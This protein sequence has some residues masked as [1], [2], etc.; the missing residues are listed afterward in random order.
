[1]SQRTP[2]G[3]PDRL[4]SDSRPT[5][6]LPPLGDDHARPAPSR[7]VFLQ[8]G[9]LALLSG[10]AR[11]AALAVS[12]PFAGQPSALK[13]QAQYLSEAGEFDSAMRDLSAAAGMAATSDADTLR[14]TSLVA[15]AGL[16]LN[17]HHSWLV[18]QCL[19][20]AN[21]V[22][23][24]RTQLRDDAAF[25]AFVAGV[26]RNPKYIDS[27]APVAAL[28]TRLA[29]LGAQ[30]RAYV[31]QIVTKERQVAGITASSK[32]AAQT[33]EAEECQRTWAIV[34]AVVLV[35]VAVVAAAMTGAATL[36]D[37]WKGTGA[38]LAKSANQTAN[39]HYQQCV[40]AAA[41]LPANQR[42]RAIA[43][44]QARWLESKAVYIV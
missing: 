44:C 26:R 27:V 12:T 14:F 40:S 6:S 32:T 39:Q 29:S 21:L 11:L 10:P 3:H 1:M 28:R 20:D 37:A 43:A 2:P 42:A 31:Q 9:A 34:T 19:A 33:A 15:N 22:S 23:W 36:A 5:A 38:D 13:S 41:A 25:N 17:H 24:A 8:S 4:D 7:R 30:K 18:A 35:V 16:K